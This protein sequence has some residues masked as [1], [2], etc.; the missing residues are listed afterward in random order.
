MDYEFKHFQVV[1]CF[2]LQK[3]INICI[4]FRTVIGLRGKD[5][6]VFAVEKLITSKLYEPGA[7]KRIFSIDKNI[8]MVSMNKKASFWSRVLFQAHNGICR[9]IT[10]REIATGR[11]QQIFYMPSP[12]IP[13]RGPH[14]CCTGNGYPEV[15]KLPSVWGYSWVILSLRSINMEAWSSMLGVGHEADNFCSV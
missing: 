5:G 3:Y 14:R 8:G 2:S 11:P 13:L 6:I 9:A 1:C 4:S 10:I 15:P 12:E 7:N